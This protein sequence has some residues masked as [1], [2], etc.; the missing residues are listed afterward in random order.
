[1]RMYVILALVA[2][3]V[4]GA[5]GLTAYLLTA[6]RRAEKRQAV[7]ARLDAVAARAAKEHKDRRAAAD[8]SAAL[9]AV[10]PAIPFTDDR[11]P[12]RRVA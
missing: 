8:A 6:A 9:T 10:L 7:A 4:L 1:M 12:P 11:K 2:L 3:L 5:A